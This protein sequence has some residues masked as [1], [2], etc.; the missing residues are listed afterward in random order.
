MFPKTNLMPHGFPN[1][2]KFNFQE[3]AKDNIINPWE[4]KCFFYIGY[5]DHRCEDSD[6]VLWKADKTGDSSV[7]MAE[8]C[9]ATDKNRSQIKI[10]VKKQV[11][12]TVW[13]PTSET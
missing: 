4:V 13:K 5:Q 10:K 2:N 12:M 6:I 9:Y 3:I 8:F 11:H 1:L 7:Y